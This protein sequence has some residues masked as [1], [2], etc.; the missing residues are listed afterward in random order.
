MTPENKLSI[1]IIFHLRTRTVLETRKYWF[2]KMMEGMGSLIYQIKFNFILIMAILMQLKSSRVDKLICQI[3]WSRLKLSFNIHI[4]R[5]KITIIQ[6]FYTKIV[7]K[8]IFRVRLGTIMRSTNNKTDRY[9]PAM[10]EESMG[11]K[12]IKTRML[13]LDIISMR[14]EVLNKIMRFKEWFPITS[15]ILCRTNGQE[16]C[17]ANLQTVLFRKMESRW[18]QIRFSKQLTLLSDRV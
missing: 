15:E 5:H 13:D 18:I 10:E 1:P 4:T 3:N 14:K 17:T 8:W 12:V 16:W 2:L 9:P 11:K 7:L 6:Q